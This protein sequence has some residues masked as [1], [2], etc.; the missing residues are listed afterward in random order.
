MT[1]S[2]FGVNFVPPSESYEA[3]S[4][5][6]FEVVE[7]GCEEEDC[8]DEYQDEVRSKQKSEKIHQ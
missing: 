6:V 2:I 7:I 3:T 8:D 5:D 1:L 4:G